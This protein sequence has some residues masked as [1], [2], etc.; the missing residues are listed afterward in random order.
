ML[1]LLAGGSAERHAGGGN[2]RQAERAY[3]RHFVSLLRFSNWS[4]ENPG[5]RRQTSPS[6]VLSSLRFVASVVT[7]KLRKSMEETPDERISHTFVTS[8]RRFS[9]NTEAAKIHGGKARQAHR[10]Y[11]RHFVSSIRMYYWSVEHPWR[12]RPPSP[13]S[14]FSSLRL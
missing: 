10:A 14:A 4:F 3:F 1:I 6:S 13:S 2:T 9:C 8:F 11:F 7:L 5:R 12:K